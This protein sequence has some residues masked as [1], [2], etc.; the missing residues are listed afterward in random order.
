[1][2][3]H[4][5]IDDDNTYPYFKWSDLAPGNYICIQ[6]PVIHK[7]MDGQ[8]GFRIDYAWQVRVITASGDL[9]EG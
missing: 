9:T 5:Y 3:M 1:M 4:F 7:F 6:M 2:M 8:T